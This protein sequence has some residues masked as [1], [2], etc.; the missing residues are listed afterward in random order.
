MNSAHR[1]KWR[2]AALPVESIRL[3]LHL[4]MLF[5]VAGISF[6]SVSLPTTEHGLSYFDLRYAHTIYGLIGHTS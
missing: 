2:A 6:A 1:S 3:W 5:T 4:T